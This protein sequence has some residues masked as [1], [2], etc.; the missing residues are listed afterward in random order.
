LEQDY[1]S[2]MTLIVRSHGDPES[3]IPTVRGVVNRLD[4]N[5]GTFGAMTMDQHLENALNL[6]KTSA[7]L[8]GAFAVIA[9]LLAVV[10]IYG[11]VSYSVA[12]RTREVGIRVAL[13]ARSQDVL[14]L[15]L[16]NGLSL[17]TAGV[18]VGLAAALA[19]SRL[20]GGMLYYI[21]ARRAA[22]VDPVTSLKAE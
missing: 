14:R 1:R 21:P 4:P 18:V 8:A 22:K 17:A 6:P 20:I 19:V 13:G 9:L 7:I 12:R 15:I 10:G 11:V 2:G 3:L 16:G 5:L